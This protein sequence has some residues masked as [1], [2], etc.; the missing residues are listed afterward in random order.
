MKVI[1]LLLYPASIYFFVFALIKKKA[2]ILGNKSAL[3]VIIPGIICGCIVLGFYVYRYWGLSIIVYAIPFLLAFAAA[4]ILYF[5]K[6][7]KASL[8]KVPA[9]AAAPVQVPVSAQAPAKVPAPA[10]SPAQAPAPAY[11]EPSPLE[12]LENFAKLYK[13]GVISEEEYNK[14]KAELL[15]QL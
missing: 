2:E 3:S 15:S 11:T 10:V 8:A 14:K 12:K 6:T 1:L 4:A 5:P 9:G 7:I 13:D